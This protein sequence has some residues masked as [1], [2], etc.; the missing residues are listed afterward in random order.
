MDNHDSDNNDDALDN[1]LEDD[2]S[3]HFLYGDVKEPDQ[4]PGTKA[5]CMGVIVLMLIPVSALWLS[6]VHL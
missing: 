4:R 5:G 1:F 2:G 3:D 6:V